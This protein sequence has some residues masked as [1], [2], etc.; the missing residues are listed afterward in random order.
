MEHEVKEVDVTYDNGTKGKIELKYP[1]RTKNKCIIVGCA[2]S[3]ELVDFNDPD[4]EYW[5]VN[6]LYGVPLKDAHYD[7]W[8]EIHNIWNDE[9]SG[10]LLRRGSTEFRGQSVPDY[11]AGLGKLGC[12]VYMQK[13]WPELVPM[14]VPYPLHEIIAFFNEKIGLDL[15]LCRYLT[16]TITYEIVLAIYLGFK[17]IEVWGVDMS[18]GDEYEA[19]RP[20]CEFWMGIAAG[21]GIKV[22][23]PSQADLLKCRFMYGFEEQLQDIWRE[24]VENVR[25]TTK[26]KRLQA[27][28]QRDELNERVLQLRG[29]EQT[30]EEINKIWRNEI[31]DNLVVQRRGTL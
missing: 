5:G 23:V 30:V 11:L 22:F 19:Q 6:N 24:K 21:M 3:K 13:H 4:A 26:L 16:N 9:R 18:L 14:S 31:D 17:Q 2:T 12:T 28:R 8:F 1:V 27:E 20:S 10:N 7:R 29:A 25:V 15:S